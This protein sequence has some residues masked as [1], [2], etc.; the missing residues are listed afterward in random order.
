MFHHKRKCTINILFQ[1]GGSAVTFLRNQWC[2]KGG[3]TVRGTGYS[4]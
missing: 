3:S 4:L 1:F 2:S